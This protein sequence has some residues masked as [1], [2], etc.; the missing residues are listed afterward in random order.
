MKRVLIIG[1]S[2][3]GKSTLAKTLSTLYML[4]V[5]HL[6]H[7]IWNPGWVQRNFN[8]FAH[9]IWELCERPTWI[10]DGTYVRTLQNR[11][12]YA[13]TII[14]LDLPRWLCIWR[15][16]KRFVWLRWQDQEIAPGCP[17]TLNRQFLWYL[18]MFHKKFRP[19]IFS[20]LRTIR[21]DSTKNIYV[22]SNGKEIK[23]FLEQIQH[24]ALSD[25]NKQSWI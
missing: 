21:D 3:S 20:M 6:D 15:V 10:I 4:P 12:E 8:D 2:G 7:Y 14:F 25:Q 17:A 23:L 19:M 11:I 18:W 9:E 22:L 16:L 1:C 5:Y 24:K 13:D